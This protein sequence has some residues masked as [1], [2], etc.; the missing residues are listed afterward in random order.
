V[1]QQI[2]KQFHHVLKKID[3]TVLYHSSMKN[4]P[5]SRQASNYLVKSSPVDLL[6]LLR[7]VKTIYY[8]TRFAAAILIVDV[9]MDE[10]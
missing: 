10:S 9:D 4:L 6:T 5:P 3:R 8:D 2:K 7:L 1:F